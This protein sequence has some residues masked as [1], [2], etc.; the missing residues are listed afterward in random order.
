MIRLRLDNC[1]PI[2]PNFSRRP[3]T[4]LAEVMRRRANAISFLFSRPVSFLS[5]VICY[6]KIGAGYGALG[7]L[8]AAAF[9]GTASD[10]CRKVFNLA[11]F[12]TVSPISTSGGRGFAGVGTCLRLASRDPFPKDA[13]LALRQI[14]HPRHSSPFRQIRHLFRRDY[15]CCTRY[16]YVRRHFGA[17]S[18]ARQC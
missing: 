1:A 5:R 4:S 12:P 8:A 10:S 11:W 14:R 3:P 15:I 16:E 2:L 13:C 17:Q 7:G 6:S 9:P 18:C